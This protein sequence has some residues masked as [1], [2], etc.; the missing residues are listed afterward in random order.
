MKIYLMMDLTMQ[1]AEMCRK[2]GSLQNQFQYR[3]KLELRF[4][5]KC[6]EG[7]IVTNKR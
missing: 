3:F 6:A 4:K 2:M 1:Y 5:M 7:V